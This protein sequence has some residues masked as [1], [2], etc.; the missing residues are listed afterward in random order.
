M[1]IRGL[2]KLHERLGELELPEPPEPPEAPE[3]PEVPE[4]P[5]PPEPPLPFLN[6]GGSSFTFFGVRPRLGIQVVDLT[7]Q[8][9][10]YFKVED[11]VLVSSVR[12][13]SAAD[14]AGLH[15]GDV[16]VKIDGTSIGSNHELVRRVGRSDRQAG[17]A[18]H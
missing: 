1:K 18:D 3:P 11:G 6:D 7:D 16:I 2:E 4:A 5:E 14:K 10:R 8:L 12:S 9:A 13:G 17:R 15:A